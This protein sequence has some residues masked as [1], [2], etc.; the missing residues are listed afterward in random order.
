MNQSLVATCRGTRET[1]Q[2]PVLDLAFL[3]QL[4]PF[5]WWDPPFSTPLNTSINGALSI[6]TN[7]SLSQCSSKFLPYAYII[8]CLT[9]R[10]Q[11]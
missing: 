1:V 11:K 6:S 10:Y 9:K 2:T 3:A 4:L 7:D 8:Q 5:L